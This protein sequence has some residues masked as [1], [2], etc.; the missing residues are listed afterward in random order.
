MKN[1]LALFPVGNTDGKMVHNCIF[2]KT[3]TSCLITMEHIQG[4]LY[5]LR[6]VKASET[7]KP[8]SY[9]TTVTKVKEA[10]DFLNCVL[11]LEDD[12]TG[13]VWLQERKKGRASV[14]A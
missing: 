8:K 4:P 3:N 13:L 7:S 10:I 11:K 9:R 14:S 2:D 5:S 12:I 6:V 1:N